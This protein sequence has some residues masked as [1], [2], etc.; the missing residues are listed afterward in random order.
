VTLTITNWDGNPLGSGSEQLLFGNGGVTPGLSAGQLAQINF[1][2]PAGFAAGTYS[3]IF[4]ATDVNEI[5]PGIAIPEP[6]TWIGAALALG[7]IGWTQ[8]K[9]L[10]GLIA[11]RA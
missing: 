6:S 5:V 8:R 9:K 11:Q 7:T 3:A 1:V 10:R 2:D 4:S